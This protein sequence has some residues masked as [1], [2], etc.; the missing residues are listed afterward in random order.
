MDENS[1]L[2]LSYLN[3]LTY[4]PR[5]FWYMYVQGELAINAPMLEGTLQHQTRAD[6]AG[7][8]TDENGRII[9]R[10]LWVWSERLQIAGF[11]DFVEVDPTATPQT[12]IPVEYKHGQKGQWD[13][14]E[15]Q[16]CAQALCLEEMTG[17]T[18]TQ[19]EI[20]Y[21][22][23]RRRVT[24]TFDQTVRQAT[25]TAVAQAHAL[26]QTNRIPAPISERKKCRHCSIQP[27]CL[28]DE[29]NQLQAVPISSWG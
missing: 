25:E 6:K 16:L 9:H 3:Q 22:R 7:Q 17:H 10:R 26:L 27:I 4:C 19:G 14:D 15:I 21:W 28:P 13:N 8:E 20:F 1:V 11:A 5:R 18:I 29:V 2:P 12:L 24:V 23:S